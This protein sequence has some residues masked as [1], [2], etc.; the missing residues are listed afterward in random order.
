M[1]SER[2]MS[3]IRNPECP[4]YVIR[5]AVLEEEAA[6][7][8]VYVIEG[9]TGEYSDRQSWSVAAFLAEEHAQEFCDKLNAWCKE[10]RIAKSNYDYEAADELRDQ[11][12]W[13]FNCP[14]D[15]GLCVYY[16]GTSYLVYKIP[17]KAG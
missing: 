14:L 13:S 9:Q 8:D 6:V 16:T 15:P 3:L 10:K 5:D 4:D 11:K 12:T 17:L 1:L 2:L 7:A